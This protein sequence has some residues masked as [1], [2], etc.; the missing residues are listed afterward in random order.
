MSES[1]IDGYK[2]DYL[3]ALLE[4]TDTLDGDIVEVEYDL[5]KPAVTEPEPPETA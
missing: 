1:L 3:V 2:L 4:S 5:K